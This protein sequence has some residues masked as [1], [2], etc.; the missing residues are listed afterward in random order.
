[1]ARGPHRQL[2]IA[3]IVLA[4]HVIFGTYGFWLPNDPRGSWSDWIAS[5]E[6][7][8]NAGAA[9]RRP[10]PFEPAPASATHPSPAQGAIR[11]PTVVLNDDQ[12]LAV[13]RGFGRIVAKCDFLVWACSIM[14]QHVHM[15]IGRH[16]YKVEQIVRLLQ[17]GASRELAASGLHPLKAYRQAHG[18]FPTVWER[19]CWRSYIDTAEGIEG[20]IGYVED[21]PEKESMPR[22]CWPF[23]M[24]VDLW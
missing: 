12:V 1:M 16:H 2:T 18:T 11:L 20:A 15:V 24:P 6:L 13:G 3:A 5:W 19:N 9:R 4:Y 23:L 21:N 22:Q 17:Q 8:R 10:S 7:L 14:R